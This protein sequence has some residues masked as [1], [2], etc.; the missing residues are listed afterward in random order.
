M[1]KSEIE[2]FHSLPYNIIG[3]QVPLNDE[4]RKNPAP[5]KKIGELLIGEDGVYHYTF[6]ITPTQNKTP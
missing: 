1:T 4:Q 6:F 2:R 3:T 5:P